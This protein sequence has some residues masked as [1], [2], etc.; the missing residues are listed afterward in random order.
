MIM[1][2]NWRN[3]FLLL[4]YYNVKIIAPVGGRLPH[5]RQEFSKYKT[6]ADQN[7]KKNEKITNQSTG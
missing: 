2:I 7:I 3:V 1:H 6:Q 4:N 5:G